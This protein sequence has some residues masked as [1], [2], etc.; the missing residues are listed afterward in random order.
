MRDPATHAPTQ[1]TP[2][3]AFSAGLTAVVPMLAGAIP[4]GLIYGVLA[5][6]GGGMAT[7]WMI[8]WLR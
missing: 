2:R 3:N 8:Q 7:L 6:I 5:T 4:F 1:H